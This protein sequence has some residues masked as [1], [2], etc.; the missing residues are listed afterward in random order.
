MAAVKFLLGVLAAL[1]VASGAAARDLQI[2]SASALP[3]EARATL[4]LIK[5]GGPYPYRQDN[6]VF[7]NREKLLPP[8]PRGY[9]R[10]YTAVRPGARQRGARRIVAGG[11]P[12]VEFFYTDDHYRSFKR[13]QEQP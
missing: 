11:N 1:F 13:I 5:Q 3:P 4:A 10:E 7:G 6:S 8:R 9:Y 12:P 2:I